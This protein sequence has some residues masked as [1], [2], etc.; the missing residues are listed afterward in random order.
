MIKNSITIL[1]VFV[2]LLLSNSAFSQDNDGMLCGTEREKPVWILR[3]EI[4]DMDS[5]APIRH[6]TIKTIGSRGRTMTWPSD[7]QGISVLVCTDERCIPSSGFLEVAARGYRYHREKME[8][9]A[10]QSL[11]ANRR[12]LL[13]GHRHNWT[14]LNRLPSIQE[15]MDKVKARQYRVGVHKIPSGMGFDWINYAP[16]LFEFRIEMERIR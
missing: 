4:V 14:D 9:Y 11:E 2:A 3:F 1:S 12:I 8:R 6:A 5:H 7:R 16:A 15:I 13:A 10:F